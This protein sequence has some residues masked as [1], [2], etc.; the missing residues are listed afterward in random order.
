MRFQAPQKHHFVTVSKRCEPRSGVPLLAM[1]KARVF[2]PRRTHGSPPRREPQASFATG[3]A[4]RPAFAHH[5]GE[6]P[7]PEQE[8]T[9]EAA[10]LR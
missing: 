6:L 10:A 7:P 5:R 1:S 4:A 3:D 8:V 9:R 2:L